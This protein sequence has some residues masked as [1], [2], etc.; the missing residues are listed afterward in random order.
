[1][2][3][4]SKRKNSSTVL[5]RRTYTQHS[6]WAAIIILPFAN[7][8]ELETEVREEMLILRSKNRAYA[9]GIQREMCMQMLLR[10]EWANFSVFFSFFPSTAA[11]TVFLALS[12]VCLVQLVDPVCV[13]LAQNTKHISTVAAPAGVFCL[14][15]SVFQ[16]QLKSALASKQNMPRLEFYQN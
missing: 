14:L 7:Q 13:C 9:F 3:H 15:C 1:M 2:V 12:V 11:T 8:A 4:T 10:A 16:Q 5:F 6:L